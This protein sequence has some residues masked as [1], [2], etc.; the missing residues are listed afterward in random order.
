M[1]FGNK[2]VRYRFII[3]L[4]FLHITINNLLLVFYSLKLCEQTRYQLVQIDSKDMSKAH[5]R[6]MWES[7]LLSYL[8]PFFAKLLLERL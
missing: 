5:P 6:T 7:R 4:H 1:I 2:I 3:K 8:V